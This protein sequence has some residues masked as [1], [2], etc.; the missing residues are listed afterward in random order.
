MQ[1]EPLCLSKKAY[2]N[3]GAVS[4][5]RLFLFSALPAG[6]AIC[7]RIKRRHS[8]IAMVQQLL[9]ALHAA[10]RP[11][12]L[13]SKNLARRMR[14]NILP[15]LLSVNPIQ[16]RNSLQVLE[17]RLPSSRARLIKAPLKNPIPPGLF[18]QC[19]P[20]RLGKVNPAAFS[21]LALRDRRARSPQKIEC[22][23]VKNYCSME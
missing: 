13:H 8:F 21:C 19:F 5:G 11:K 4:S 7:K 22:F 14:R 12:I 18:Q 6:Q 10:M 23:Q 15:Q 2:H 17:H 20:Q 16:R 3:T 1:D 9:H